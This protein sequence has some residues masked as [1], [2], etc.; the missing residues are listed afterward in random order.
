[1]C[2]CEEGGGGGGFLG[3]LVCVISAVSFCLSEQVISIKPDTTV[4]RSVFL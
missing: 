1:M 2:V 4:A 3:F